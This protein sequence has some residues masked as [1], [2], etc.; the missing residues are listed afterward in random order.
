M[1]CPAQQGRV[2]SSEPTIRTLPNPYQVARVIIAGWPANKRRSRRST[3][4]AVEP[5]A[6]RGGLRRSLSLRRFSLL[7]VPHF[8]RI[9]RFAVR[10]VVDCAVAAVTIRC[11]VAST[12]IGTA[13]CALGEGAAGRRKRACLIAENPR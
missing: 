2:P 4:T 7:P 8:R 11:I 6:E 12:G 1:L 9:A 5:G 13:R 10:R 3:S